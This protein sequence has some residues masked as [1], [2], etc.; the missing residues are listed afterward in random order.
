MRLAA[1]LIALALAI[2]GCQATPE[3]TMATA[4]VRDSAGVEI[5]TNTTPAWREGEG[6]QVDTVPMTVIGADE[7]DPQQQWKYV[8][9]AA[10][11][12]DGSIAVA[13]DGSIRLFGADGRFV[14]QISRAGEGPGEF[15]Y[16]ADLLTLPGDTLRA[17]EYF[18]RRIAYFTSTGT[19]LREERLDNEKIAHFGPWSEC[20]T[21]VLADGSRYGCKEDTTIAATATNRREVPDGGGHTALGPGLLRK[22]R[23]LWVVPPA[24]DTAY[25]LGIDAGIE[26][27][28]VTLVPGRETFVVHPFHGWSHVATGGV[29]PHIAIAANPDYRVEMWTATG[30]LERI[31]QRTGARFAPTEADR[32]RAREVLLLQYQKMDQ[33]TRDRMLA[34]VPTPD[35]F[36]AV[37]GLGLTP[38]GE[39]LVQREV[40]W[41]S[42][43][44]S[45]W[46]IFDPSGHFLGTI[47]IPG[48]HRLLAAGMDHLLTIRKTEDE[49]W[50]V[51]VYGIKR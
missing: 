32:A 11:L 26:Q 1:L 40:P 25:P 44:G 48:A 30:K 13:A 31:I 45:A 12:S 46:D 50:L 35:S 9:G 15:R 4:S 21:G 8:E 16:L 17:S 18:G 3:S 7:S 37:L 10:R 51:E 20:N 34:Q 5:V 36:P 47:R 29:P 39:L 23:R 38:A 27:F 19:L 22:L 6:W 41:P 33:A 24:L 28:G 2:G 14:R 49:A 42:Q 43:R